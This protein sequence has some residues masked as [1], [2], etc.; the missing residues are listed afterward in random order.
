MFRLNF[1]LQ[2]SILNSRW[3][4]EGLTTDEK[5]D[6]RQTHTSHFR[7]VSQLLNIVE[8]RQKRQKLI[9]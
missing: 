8:K 7:Q 2:D 6:N 3:C 9:V 1:F 5:C 4:T